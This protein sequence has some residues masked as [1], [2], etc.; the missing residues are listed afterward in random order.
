MRLPFNTTLN[1]ASECWTY[2]K[3]AI[4]STT[5]VYKSWLAAHMKII[6]NDRLKC[7]FGE[8]TKIYDWEHYDSILRQE[9]LRVWDVKPNE[10]V[11]TIIN[12]IKC[13]KYV[14][15]DLDLN[16]LYRAI[17][18]CWGNSYFHNTVFYGFDSKRQCL[19]TSL[20][21]D[22]EFV[23]IEIM[24]SEVIDAYRTAYEYFK[25]HTNDMIG[26]WDWFYNISILSLRDDY[27]ATNDI[28]AF[29]EKISSECNDEII[30][31]YGKDNSEETIYHG[32]GCF[33]YLGER[34]E[35]FYNSK[36]MSKEV[37]FYIKQAIFAKLQYCLFYIE[38]NFF[39]H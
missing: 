9:A 19:Y 22:G 30:K 11:E 16:V 35:F 15:V 33:L 32:I 24:Y 34:M 18:K 29:F 21:I 4:I 36:L 8:N 1:F 39:A 31:V 7:Y 38:F 10:I 37:E 23:E 12:Y 6:M 13:G 17:G 28:P 3:L 5:P 20:L 2:Y 25:N 14:S 27:C 26:K